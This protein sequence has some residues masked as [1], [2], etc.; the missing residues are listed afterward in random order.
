MSYRTVCKYNYVNTEKCAYD[1]NFIFRHKS[2]IG[3]LQLVVNIVIFH[4]AS[5]GRNLNLFVSVVPFSPSLF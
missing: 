5:I 3:L 4:E 1:I 2:S